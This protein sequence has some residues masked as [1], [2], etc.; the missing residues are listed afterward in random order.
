M[1]RLVHFILVWTLLDLGQPLTLKSKPAGKGLTPA[2]KPDIGCRT[3]QSKPKFSRVA[4]SE[5]P[6][7]RKINFVFRPATGEN[8]RTALNHQT[9]TPLGWE[10]YDGSVYTPERGYGWLTNLRGHGRDR[11]THGIVR[12]ADGSHTSPHDLGRPELANF[13]G[14]HQENQLLVFRMDLEDGWY[15]VSCASVDPDLTRRKPLIDQRS[16]KCRSYDAVFAG[17]QY[18]E[19]L[20]AGG[21]Q[22]VEGSGVVEVTDGHLR[23]V[24]GDP[25]YAGWTWTYPGRWY[26]ELKHWWR[27]EYNY[28]NNWYQWLTRTVDPG[29]HTLGLNS[30]E[31][32]PVAAPQA[33]AQLVFRDLFNRDDDPDVNRGVPVGN[34]WTVTRMRPGLPEVHTELHKTSIKSSASKLGHSLGSLMQ[35]RVSPDRGVVRY[36]TRVSLF[37]GEGSRKHSGIQEAGVVLLAQPSRPQEYNSTFVGIQF[38]SSRKNT[39]GRLIYRIGDGQ[40]GYRTALEI[41]DTVLPFK[42]TEGEFEIIV[43]HD[44]AK[45]LLRQ[46]KVNGIDV[47][48]RFSLRD[49]SQRAPRG[50]FGIRSEIHNT[51]P[52]VSLQQYYWYYRVESLS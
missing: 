7:T 32:R 29:F 28:V 3:G 15:R 27:V 4:G 26:T 6:C 11:G 49:R 36:S 8:L 10:S 23:I 41:P 12:L 25:A 51:N 45:N 33:L 20:V 2:S 1:H 40:A 16:F 50:L 43:E 37:T 5:A 39:K 22:L 47:T 24:I 44:V 38:D 52:R 34:R 13:Q 9:P 35:Q 17:A 42:I 18:G 31:V 14:T 30:L 19:P 21:R 46:I 48:D